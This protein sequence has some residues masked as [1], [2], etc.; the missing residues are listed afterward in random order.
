MKNIK[1]LL[2][3]FGLL[4][5]F[6][7]TAAAQ[8]ITFSSLDGEKIDLQSQKGKVVVMAI[9]A[10]WLPLSKG[11][12]DAIN[13]LARKYAGRDVSF[14]FIATDSET[15]KSK[16]YASND[17]IR[18][19]GESN[20]LTVSI[21]RDSEGLQTIKQYKVDQLPAFIILDKNG[22]LAM[23]PFGGIDPKNDISLML[24]SKIDEIL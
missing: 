17:A 2:A 13:K 4:I 15:E 18:K 16:N 8:N 5:A 19:F 11:Q 14:F 21:L 3:I 1:S 12:A 7:F 20:K 6:S 9:G 10:S 23:E 24:S 22:K